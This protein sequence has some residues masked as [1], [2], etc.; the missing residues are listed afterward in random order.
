MKVAGIITYTVAVSAHLIAAL[1][2]I[3]VDAPGDGIGTLESG[4]SISHRTLLC[5]V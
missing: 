4:M 2:S 5:S 3:A 1:P